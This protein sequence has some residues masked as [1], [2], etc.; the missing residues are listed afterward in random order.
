MNNLSKTLAVTLINKDGDEFLLS[1]G[2]IENL[3]FIED[4]YSFC[5]VGKLSFLDTGGIFEFGTFWGWDDEKIRIT[6]GVPESSDIIKEYNIYKIAKQAPST[7]SKMQTNNLVEVL[8]VS[9]SYYNWHYKQYSLSFKDKKISYILNHIMQHMIGEEFDTFEA[10]NE[11]IPYFYTGLL[12]P[13]E[14][15]KYLM[16]RATG[17]ETG[18][19]GYV[20][21]ENSVG[22]NLVSLPKIMNNS[23]ELMEPEG[24]YVFSASN[25]WYQ[26]NI[27]SFE[28]E[29]IDNSSRQQLSGGFRTG[30]D[31]LRKKNFT[32]EFTYKESRKDVEDSF[33]GDSQY[34]L[35]DPNIT[36]QEKYI[37]T[38][39]SDETFVKN[40]YNSNWIKQYSNQQL[41]SIYLSGHE[42]RH[43]G[44]IIEIEWNSNMS[45]ELNQNFTGKY[46]VKSVIN[47]FYKEQKPFYN[48]KLV[49]MKN[50]Y[51]RIIT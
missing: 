49:L 29:G 40:I 4:I 5:M 11:T 14:N 39:E 25:A 15:F 18:K 20:C 17:I 46:F 16:E 9:T 13:A 50:S 47:Y 24:K 43:A 45:E 42:K 8:F 6:Y 3:Y 31:M 35:F 28:R 38:G 23:N 48:Q 36:G 10:T 32:E 26:N 51:D 19:A 34:P 37:K 41:I 27:L 22:W 21:F 1:T 7:G 30:Y 2:T 44:G 12:S 33:M